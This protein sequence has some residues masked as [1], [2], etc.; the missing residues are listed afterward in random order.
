M[1]PAA[2]VV[3]WAERVDRLVKDSIN[4]CNLPLLRTFWGENTPCTG[5]MR[6]DYNKDA[7]KE[8]P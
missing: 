7:P 3:E 4:C 6:L 5:L 8:R 1:N 2:A